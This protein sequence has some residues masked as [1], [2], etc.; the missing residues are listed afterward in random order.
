MSDGYLPPGCTQW[1]CDY[2]AQDLDPPSQWYVCDACGGEGSIA[3][4]ITVYEPGCGFP[5]GDA[6]EKPCP[7]CGGAGGF[8]DEVE[9]DA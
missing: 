2:Q 7:T 9:A 1:E 5:H 3:Y 6:A 4:A 8:I